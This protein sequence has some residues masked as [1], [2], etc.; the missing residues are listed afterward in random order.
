MKCPKCES[1][2]YRKNGRRGERQNYLCKKCGRQFTEPSLLQV[3]KKT[4]IDPGLVSNNG[5]SVTPQ[6]EATILTP[7]TEKPT[8]IEPTTLDTSTSAIVQEFLKVFSSPEFLE[9]SAFQ[10]VLQKIQQP[11]DNLPQAKD[12]EIAILLLDIE[13]L[14]LDNNIEKF[15]GTLCKYPLQVKIA[16]ANWRNPTIGKQDTELY[17]RGYQLIHVP[18]GNSS[19]D[20]KMIAVGSSLFLQ[21]PRVKEVFVCSGDWL[22]IHLCNQ[23]QNLGINV[24][25]VRRQDNTLKVENC[26]TG[27]LNYYSIALKTEIP[28]FEELAQKIEDII[29][30]E[31]QAIADRLQK[32]STVAMLFQEQRQLT[33]LNQPILIAQEQTDSEEKSTQPVTEEKQQEKSDTGKA[34]LPTP[35]TRTINSREEFEQGLILSLERIKI[36]SPDAKVSVSHLG[37]EFRLIY[38]KSVSSVIHKLG[39]SGSFN[40]FLQGCAAFKILPNDKGGEVE[41]AKPSLSGIKSRTDLE[42]AL[43]NLLKS[44]TENSPGSYVSLATFGVRFSQVYGEA[45]GTVME[46]LNIEVKFVTLLKSCSAFK[47]EQTTKG[48]QVAIA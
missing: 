1:T 14:K 15:L 25:W 10:Q 11:K 35:T 39:L 46:N 29:K 27:E 12:E 43:V 13:N 34:K 28:S 4:E 30:V 21:Y 40:E 20:A 41:I 45:V 47:M 16:F 9:S 37:T 17:E 23:L 36:K 2:H 6:V 8:E 26:Q 44:I 3:L 38:K 24:Y 22:L 5:H 19:A 18:S 48:W 42:K 33:S 32:L 7:V 31:E